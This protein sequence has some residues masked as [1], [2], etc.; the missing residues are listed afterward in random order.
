MNATGA[1]PGQRATLL[2]YFCPAAQLR[3]SIPQAALPGCLARRAYGWPAALARRMEHLEK[4]SSMS[5]LSG[6]QI[7]Y[8]MCASESTSATGVIRYEA[9]IEG[10]L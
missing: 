10:T 9:A 4:R 1:S 8:L 5:V 2:A 7:Y 3:A 6:Q